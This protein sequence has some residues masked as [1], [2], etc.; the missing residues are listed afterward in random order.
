[1]NTKYSLSVIYLFCC[2]L[3]KLLFSR[4]TFQISA[5]KSF[6]IKIVPLEMRVLYSLE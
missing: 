6:D 4:H 1:M 5:L 2:L 3:K